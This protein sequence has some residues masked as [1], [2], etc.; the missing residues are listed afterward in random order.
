MIP[1]KNIQ[2]ISSPYTPHFTFHCAVC[3]GVGGSHSGAAV[4]DAAPGTFLCWACLPP[5]VR[6][7]IDE[8]STMQ[9]RTLTKQQKHDARVKIVGPWQTREIEQRARNRGE[10]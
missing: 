5:A 1:G 4:L 9:W 3:D 8:A 6:P 7:I 10:L 2:P